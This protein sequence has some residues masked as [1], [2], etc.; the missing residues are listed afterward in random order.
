MGQKRHGG[1][2]SKAR[3][4]KAYRPRAALPGGGLQVLVNCEDRFRKREWERKLNS[5][6]DPE[7]LTDLGTAYWAAF[8][9]LKLHAATEDAWAQVCV[10]SNWGMLLCEQVFDDDYLDTFVTA[11]EALFR[12]KQRGDASGSFRLDGEGL[13]AV[14]TMLQVHDEQMKLVTPADL[15]RANDTMQQRFADGHVYS[16]ATA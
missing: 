8:E 10:A 2:A 7:N 12:A 9:Q 5:P 4:K 11:Q 3:R 15:M 6:Y 13:K 1:N 16:T 14:S